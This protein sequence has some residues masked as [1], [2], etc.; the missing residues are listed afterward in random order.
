M[1]VP[2]PRPDSGPPR[3]RSHEAAA[4]ALQELPRALSEARRRFLAVNGAAFLL[5]ASLS[6]TAGELFA[7]R[8]VSR[9]PLG[10]VLGTLQLAVLLLSSWWYDRTLRRGADPLV[11]LMRRRAELVRPSL[12]QPGPA[13]A[14]SRWPYSSQGRRR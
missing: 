1:S 11:D 13:G 9:M 10:I 7:T 2:P 12:P 6:G 14:V 5:T 4:S 8:L 3:D